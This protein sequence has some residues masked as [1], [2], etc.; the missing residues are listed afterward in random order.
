LLCGIPIGNLTSQI[1]ANIYM[2]ELDQFVK[3]ELREKY[4]IRYC[5]D[6]VILANSREHLEELIPVLS[7]FLD[8]K[9]KLRLHER[10][11]IIRKLRQ[12]IDFLGYVVLP[13]H[14]M[15]RTKTKKRMFR[16]VNQINLPSYLGLLE[17]CKGYKLHQKLLET[18]QD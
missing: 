4:Y 13:H 12:G 11:I 3:H 6:F 1:F 16:K 10:K 8:E 2:N 9:L 14:I 7:Q 15:L 5:D 17:H 18:I